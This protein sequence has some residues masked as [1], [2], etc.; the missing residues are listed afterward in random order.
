ME[1]RLLV[2]PTSKFAT[3]VALAGLATTTLAGAF[4][5]TAS[6]AAT[7]CPTGSTPVLG[8]SGVC[9]VTFTASG[10]QS[11]T[12]P[13]DVSA[14][15]VLSVGGGG[16]GAGGGAIGGQ[17]NESGYAPGG[18]GGGGQVVVSTKAVAAGDSLA[19]AV[20]DG[21]AGGSAIDVATPAAG[22]SGS[23]G[24]SSSVSDA[25]S[26][27][28]SAA[29][30]AGGLVGNLA[31][32]DLSSGAGGASGSGNA[33]GN[34][35]GALSSDYPANPTMNLTAGGGGGQGAAG[36]AATPIDSGSGGAGAAPGDSG[37]LIGDTT[38]FGGGGG[39]GGGF[40]YSPWIQVS[41]AQGGAGGGGTGGTIDG[42]TPVLPQNGIANTGGGG[43]G[44]GTDSI[45]NATVGGDGGSGFVE[46]LF[47]VSSSG[48]LVPS[49]G[50]NE[51]APGTAQLINPDGS[52][53]PL[54]ITTTNSTTISVGNQTIGMTLSGQSATNAVLNMTPGGQ[55]STT[56][57][58]FLPGSTVQIYAFSTA[59]SLGTATVGSDGTFHAS[60]PV[61][62]TLSIGNHTIQAQG[63][64]SDGR[65]RALAAGVT[66]G[67][68]AALAATGS[69]IGLVGGAGVAI[70]LLGAV[71][72]MGS[73]TRRRRNV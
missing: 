11:W 4:T 46:I 64:G 72:V 49:S 5:M 66:I 40:L 70:A 39:G 13:A 23:S 50:S 10:A 3:G 2:T 60:F 47:T 28:L 68:G 41:G 52:V 54:S 33:G 34:T 26:W 36:G 30:G 58:G 17:G 19:I 15:T 53:T 21:G 56:G 6:G 44:G 73:S 51:L 45:P 62:A 22:T 57:Y 35:S 9:E 55:G 32:A 1:R 59:T 37:F 29:G 42:G 18:G 69:P 8:Q 24:M 31:S 27:S 63:L 67:A 38:V 71:V 61:P 43:G 65:L 25:S 7:T 14:I 20:G 48:P 16:G 12:V